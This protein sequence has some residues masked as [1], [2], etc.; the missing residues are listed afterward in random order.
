MKRFFSFSIVFLAL[1][2]PVLEA[3]AQSLSLSVEREEIYA[4]LPFV[5]SVKA[6]GFDEEPEP[7]ATPFE[8][9]GCSIRYLGLSPSVQ[10]M[11]QIINGRKSEFRRVSFVYRYRIEAEKPGTYRI[12]ALKVV[13]GQKEAKSAP[14][15]FEVKPV[16]M[17][18]D[19]QIRL[20]LPKRKLWVGE[21]F[22]VYVDWYLRK[23]VNGQTFVVPLLDMADRFDVKV[24]EPDGQKTL[25]FS[26]G[27]RDLDVPYTQGQERL[28]GV[29]YTRFRFSLLLT[30]N[31]FGVI[32]VPPA[33]VAAKLTVGKARDF[34]GFSRSR[35]ALFQA[36][37]RPRKLEIVA[38]PKAG[39]PPS[40]KNAIGRSFSIRVRADRTVVRVGDP[41]QLTVE[42]RGD[43]NLSGL[44]LPRLDVPGGLSPALFSVPTDDAPSELLADGS[45]RSFEVLIRLKS[46]AATKIPPLVFSYFDP[47][48]GRYRTVRSEPIALS[49]A[50]SSRI[51]AKDVVSDVEPPRSVTRRE[52]AKT[53][54]PNIRL[55]GADLALS[56]EGETLKEPLGLSLASPTIQCLYGVPFFLFLFSVF[57][58]NSRGRREEESELKARLKG[59]N[60]ALAAAGSAPA[61]MSAATLSKEIRELRRSLNVPPE[62]VRQVL[63]ELERMAYDPD[64]RDAPL[65]ASLL[66]TIRDKLTAWQRPKA[67]SGG[68]PAIVLFLVASSLFGPGLAFSSQYEAQLKDARESYQKALSSEDADERRRAFK[69]AYKLLSSVSETKVDRPELLTDLGNAALGSGEFGAAMLAFRRTLA[70]DS[71]HK[72][73][74]RNVSW[75]RE[76]HPSWYPRAESETPVEAFF[77]WHTRMN[78]AQKH[79]VGAVAF[80][81]AF[82]L[83]SF[84][85]ASGSRL[86]GRIAAAFLFFWAAMLV[87][88]IADP[89]LSTHAVVT[90]DGA[91]L[92]AADSF[93][94]PKAFPNPLP[95]G[96]EL[97][98]VEVRGTWSKVSLPDGQT[99]WIPANMF[100]RVL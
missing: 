77:F 31:Q 97:E 20:V 28:G 40:F 51:G 43:G 44:Q 36:R 94:A 45:G 42:I 41:M 10:S 26:V 99:G 23:D 98:V 91:T 62:E 55:L 82:L 29:Q 56:R 21:T 5:L 86:A 70:L 83:L 46:A 61:K 1:L 64:R 81:L 63:A 32:D 48:K 80:A 33:R 66:D 72:R 47:Y 68:G 100:T 52:G 84:W 3:G 14:T 53:K 15:K 11:V 6:E 65:P 60:D 85:V 37:D 8:I 16:R 25:P 18:K 58:R 57:R 17:S 87:S 75:L 95:A 22:R 76:Q 93:G 71:T 4:E 13:Q 90:T 34:F 30:P 27:A 74:K 92:H 39:R 2:G 67:G 9:P 69:K 49:V 7:E 38:L 73:A 35:T 88:L 54:S 50:G 19:M 59:V 96:A 89:N 24:E 78:S 79:L 12:P